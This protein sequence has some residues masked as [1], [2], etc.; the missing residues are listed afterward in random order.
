MNKY[1]GISVADTTLQEAGNILVKRKERRIGYFTGFIVRVLIAGVMGGALFGIRAANFSFSP[2]VIDTVKSAITTD[3]IGQA[4][5]KE[6][7]WDKIQVYLP[8]NKQE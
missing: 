4:D 1:D 2:L 8:W 3:F 5:D 7:L 6:Y